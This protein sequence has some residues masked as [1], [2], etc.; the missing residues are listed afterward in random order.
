ME[1]LKLPLSEALPQEEREPDELPLSEGLP[2]PDTAGDA[3]AHSDT[4]HE[5]DATRVVGSAVRLPDTEPEILGDTEGHELALVESLTLCVGDTDGD[6]LTDAR[7][8]GV[9]YAV[10]GSAEKLDD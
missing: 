9:S 7:L 4:V 2:L 8:E 10:V 3:D 6:T 5:R 1:G